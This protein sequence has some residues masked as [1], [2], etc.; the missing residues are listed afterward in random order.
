M[1]GGSCRP[2]SAAEQVESASRGL[3]RF[4][5]TTLL[6]FHHG[7]RYSSTW[8]FSLARIQ[9]ISSHCWVNCRPCQVV[10]T[11]Y[12]M[13]HSKN[14]IHRPIHDMVF[15]AI[16]WQYIY[17]D[18]T[19]HLKK[20]WC[21]ILLDFLW[22]TGNDIMNMTRFA[23]S[24]FSCFESSIAHLFTYCVYQAVEERNVTDCDYHWLIVN[25]KYVRHHF[26]IDC[27]L[28]DFCQPKRQ[29]YFCHILQ[30][31]LYDFI[32]WNKINVI[33]SKCYQLHWAF[34]KHTLFTCWKYDSYLSCCHIWNKNRTNSLVWLNGRLC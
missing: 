25:H 22:S 12:I 27:L 15:S 18:S 34:G 4:M 29:G 26:I 1:L 21:S 11:D 17:K 14:Q 16:Y 24:F 32:I 6:V 31:F 10:T 8:I 19:M 13:V 5:S 7:S 30:K 3:L 20:N 23:N 2:L 9:V 33:L 28:C